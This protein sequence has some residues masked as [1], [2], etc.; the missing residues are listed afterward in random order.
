[1]TDTVRK[2]KNVM[3]IVGM[4]QCEMARR[5]GVNKGIISKVIRGLETPSIE[6]VEK[7][8]KALDMEIRLYKEDG[9]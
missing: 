4:S 8:V 6:I 7:M 3:D 2:I 5:S 9:F 1:M